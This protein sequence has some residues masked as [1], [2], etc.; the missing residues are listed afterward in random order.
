M[1]IGVAKCFLWRELVRVARVIQNSCGRR[2]LIGHGLIQ[3]LLILK[4]AG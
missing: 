3:Q 4:A 2:D 1:F